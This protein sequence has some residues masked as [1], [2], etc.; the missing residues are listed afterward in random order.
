[1]ALRQFLRGQRRP[2]RVFR[3]A[4]FNELR[5]IRVGDD[6]EFPGT[7]G[8]FEI[9]RKTHFS[10]NFAKRYGTMIRAL[11]NMLLIAGLLVSS[12]SF[13][14]L[15]VDPF[16]DPP[17][18]TPFPYYPPF[19]PSPFTPLLSSSH[20]AATDNF[21]TINP[22]QHTSSIM[23]YGYFDTG[24]VAYVEKRPQNGT[25][26]FRRF[27]NP[28]QTDHVYVYLPSEVNY[29]LANGWHEEVALNGDGVPH[30]PE[31]YIYTTQRPGTV[32]LYRANKTVPGIDHQH[33]YTT[34]YGLINY[35]VSQGWGYDGVAGYVYP[36]ASSSIPGG[37]AIGLR[38]PTGMPTCRSIP[39]DSFFGEWYR[40]TTLRPVG[41]TTQW[42]EFDFLSYDV[43][44]PSVLEHFGVMTRAC[45]DRTAG[46]EWGRWGLCNGFLYSG[47]GIAFGQLTCNGT[48]GFRISVED[49]RI[50]N[51]GL[52]ESTCTP[53]LMVAGTSY[54]VRVESS[55]SGLVSWTVRNASSNQ[56][57]TSGS[58][59][60][61]TLPGFSG[62]TGLFITTATLGEKDYTAYFTNLSNGWY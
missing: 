36:S 47:V 6:R 61:P 19:N 7:L 53:Q 3:S 50:G 2:V 55:D 31:G 56:L 5:Q 12:G 35:L 1:M 25:A 29:V 37:V 59:T 30:S 62:N 60:L 49:F 58:T 11:Q 43:F 57:I 18:T 20:S 40:K 10:F 13:A 8:G 44:D 42:V 32:A 33:R 39:N 34:S 24:T 21:Y 28:V 48:S 27:Y 4:T 52:V 16:I 15:P 14:V 26:P 51:Y 17:G 22:S 41:T 23:T 54:R 9:G 46:N 38:C 45:V